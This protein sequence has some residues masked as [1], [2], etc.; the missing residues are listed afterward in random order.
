M[1][2]TMQTSNAGDRAAPGPERDEPHAP[3]PSAFAALTDLLALIADP[4]AFAAR[5][6]E[7]QRVI[8]AAASGQ[9]KLAADR[10]AFAEHE[11]TVRAELDEESE[12]ITDRRNAAY[13]A[14]GLI[15]EREQRIAKLE[16]AW[17]HLGEPDDVISGFRSPANTPLEKAQRAFTRQREPD[18]SAPRDAHSTTRSPPW[19]TKTPPPPPR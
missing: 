8:A 2:G 6:V 5:V 1:R 18:E 10:L 14:E 12:K 3:D 13:A 19:L 9:A 7:F 15:E 11:K 4:R 16:K 17:R